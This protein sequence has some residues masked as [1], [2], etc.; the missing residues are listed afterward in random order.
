MANARDVQEEITTFWDES[1][2]YRRALWQQPRVVAL[3]VLC[4]L[5]HAVRRGVVGMVVWVPILVLWAGVAMMLLDSAELARTLGDA[6]RLFEANPEGVRQVT[7]QCL[8]LLGT[9]IA[10]G[11]LLTPGE[12]YMDRRVREHMARWSRR[13]RQE[14]MRCHEER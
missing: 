5:W 2:A 7:A 1:H 13:R 8:W 11:V 9:G 4:G 3:H 12:S 14:E 6:L 10:A